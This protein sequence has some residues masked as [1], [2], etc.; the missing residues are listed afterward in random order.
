LTGV[1]ESARLNSCPPGGLTTAPLGI[2]RLTLVE[3]A[4]LTSSQVGKLMLLVDIALAGFDR[5]SAATFTD[6]PNHLSTRLL[7][8]P[9]RRQST[10]FVDCQ[11]SEEE[12][13]AVG[14]LL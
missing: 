9:T 3:P 13:Q 4:S 1:G 2:E 6:T 10:L 5:A 12:A 8:P 14:L 7:G 11:G